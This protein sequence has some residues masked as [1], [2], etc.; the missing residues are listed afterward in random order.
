MNGAVI[1]QFLG[2]LIPLA[3]ASHPVD[4]AVKHLSRVGPLASRVL[5]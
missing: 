3:T 5:V 2:Q 1:P 4:H